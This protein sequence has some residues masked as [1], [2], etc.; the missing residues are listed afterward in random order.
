MITGKDRYDETFTKHLRHP[1]MNKQSSIVVQIA[2]GTFCGLLSG[3]GVI[4]LIFTLGFAFRDAWV[5]S[6]WPWPD[7][8]LSYLFVGSIL[9]AIALPI[10]WI[11]FS[12]E[13]AAMRAGALDLALS[14]SGIGVYLYWF[15]QQAGI[16]PLNLYTLG[17]AVA[18]IFNLVLYGLSRSIPFQ[19]QRPVPCL[20]RWSFLLFALILIAVSTALLLQFPH[21]FPWPLKN[22]TSVLIGWI[23]LGA[24]VY[25]IYGFLFPV[26]GNASGQLLGFLA[27]DLV[28]LWPFYQHL[29]TVKQAHWLSLVVYIGVLIYSALLA[30]YYLFLHPTTRFWKARAEPSLSR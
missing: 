1:G 15:Y 17:T 12:G 26:W 18:V 29:A 16:D 28:L 14:C 3:W 7:G 2:Q 21:V 23:F 20:I 13:L 6:L 22:Q 9:A 24:A 19:D 25:F 5:I 27:Y 4:L 30:V 11:G 10:I 8:R